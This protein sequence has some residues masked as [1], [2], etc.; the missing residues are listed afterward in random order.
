[1]TDKIERRELSGNSREEKR[2]EM[3]GKRNKSENIREN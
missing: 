3:K 1:M 2:R